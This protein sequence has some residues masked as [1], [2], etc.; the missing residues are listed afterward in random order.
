MSL[1]KILKL[2]KK[3]SNNEI[4]GNNFVIGKEYIAIRFWNDDI[5]PCFL[6]KYVGFRLIP[7]CINGF[8]ENYVFDNNGY[9][10]FIERY[11]IKSYRFF[12]LTSDFNLGKVMDFLNTE[13]PKKKSFSCSDENI[14]KTESIISHMD[15]KKISKSLNTTNNPNF[16]EIL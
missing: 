2:K 10:T 3:L 1:R 5:S 7:E 16:I 13:E 15:F 14:E 6:G 9:E 8:M 4:F 11:Y 12:F